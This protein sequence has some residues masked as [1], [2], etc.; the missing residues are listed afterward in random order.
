[1]KKNK[2]RIKWNNIIVLFNI[3]TM[4]IL[5]LTLNNNI[6]DNIIKLSIIMILF[7]SSVAI[8]SK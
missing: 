5:Y 8:S 2:I 6:N 7:L 3:I 4:F 1:M